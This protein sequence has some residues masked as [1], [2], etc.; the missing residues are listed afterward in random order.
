MHKMA[1]YVNFFDAISCASEQSFYVIDFCKK[2]W[3]PMKTTEKK[4]QFHSSSTIH[5]FLQILG[6]ACKLQTNE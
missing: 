1:Y 3:S 5:S 6:L 2:K 4:M